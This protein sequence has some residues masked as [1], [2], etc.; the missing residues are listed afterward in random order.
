MLFVISHFIFWR[1]GVGVKN[2][3]I[4]F[5]ARETAGLGVPGGGDREIH[6]IGDHVASMR[7]KGIITGKLGKAGNRQQATGN[8]E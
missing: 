7:Q 8:R 5:R 3:F 6:W 2:F 1:R 4:Y